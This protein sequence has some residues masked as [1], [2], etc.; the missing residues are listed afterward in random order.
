MW[1]FCVPT[2]D[3]LSC[4]VF[5]HLFTKVFFFF[6]VKHIQID[7]VRIVEGDLRCE[8]L[9]LHLERTNSPKAVFLSED[10][11]GVVSKIVYDS[12]TNQLV[13][14]VLPFDDKTGIPKSFSFK[15]ESAEMI[16]EYM[17]LP[18]SILVYIVAAQPLKENS[19]PF[20]LQV[21]GTDSK[22]D[23]KAVLKRWIFTESE[24]QK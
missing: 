5:L 22:F 16:E 1:S 6:T 11:S 21:F 14:L 20:I 4:Y 15:A 10:A 3:Y 19:I 13:G 18:Q 17:K 2:S 9:A 24:L 7:K 8:Q 23:A 12:N